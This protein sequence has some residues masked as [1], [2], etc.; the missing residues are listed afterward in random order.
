LSNNTF[1]KGSVVIDRSGPAGNYLYYGVREF[2]M[3]AIMN[4]IALHGG[5]V[6]Y[7]G[8]FLTFSDYSRNAVRMAALMGIRVLFIFTH[9]SVGLGEDGPTH[10]PIEH[11]ASLRLIPN[12]SLWRPCDVVETAVAWKAAVERHHGPT[13]LAFSRQK[14]FHQPRSPEQIEA[15]QRGGY[16]LVDCQGTPEAIIIATGSE[17]YLVMGA[18]RQLA[19]RGRKIRVVSMPSVDVF[20]AQDAAYR[21]AVLPA[22]ITKRLVVEAGVT[23]PWYKYVGMNGKIIGLDRFGASAPSDVLFKH[24]GFTVEKV[25]KTVEEF[26]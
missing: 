15:I 20:E 2:G 25:I 19:A 21:E 5:F 16:V 11:L 23:A 8:T 17:V 22:A 3:S 6:P 18:A 10:H 14:L 26:F 9:D 13:C 7:G 24:F 4:G 12:L 1:W